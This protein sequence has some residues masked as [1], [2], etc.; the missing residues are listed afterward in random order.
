[1]AADADLAL[2]HHGAYVS[3]EC[4]AVRLTGVEADIAFERCG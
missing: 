1:V 4:G 3:L 2:T